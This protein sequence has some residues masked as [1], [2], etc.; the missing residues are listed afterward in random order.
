MGMQSLDLAR[1]T[2]EPHSFYEMMFQIGASNSFSIAIDA[3]IVAGSTTDITV[4]VFFV[5]PTATIITA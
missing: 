1:I 5:N 2:V 3:N 4:I